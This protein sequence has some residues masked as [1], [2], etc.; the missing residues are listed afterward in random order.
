[1]R[2]NTSIIYNFCLLVGDGLSIV[3]GLS[4]AYILRVS[5]DHRATSA[6]IYAINYLKFL[7]LLVPFWLIVFG[8]LGLYKESGYQNRFIELGKVISGSFIGILFLISYSYMLNV[9]IFPA[10]LVVIYG[11]AFSII[12]VLI[13]RNISRETQKHLF[14]VGI[15]TNKAL[16]IG[17]NPSARSLI[18]HLRNKTSGYEVVGIVSA[19]QSN[20]LKDSPFKIY[21][22]F[23]QL[24]TKI[25]GKKVH[26]I[27]QTELYS[28]P[29]KNDQVL[30]FSQNNHIAYKFI[31]G[32]EELFTGNIKTDLFNS[33]PIISVHQTALIGWGKVVKR[34]MD[35]ILGIF[36]VVISSPVWLVVIVLQFISS[37]KNSIFYSTP[38][39]SA[40][41]KKVKIYKFRTIKP[42]YNG[43][44]PEEAFKIM[45]KEY[46]IKE[47][48][49]NGDFLK[50]DP[51]TTKFS[52]F[53]RRYSIDELPQL[54]N[55]I[56]GDISLVGP[57]ALD[58]FELN[59]YD[60]KDLIL[61]IKSGLTGLAQISGRRE[62]NFEE[63]RNLD[64]YYV[65]NWSFWFDL[66]ILARTFSVVLFHKGAI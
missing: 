3:F 25:N 7:F 12:S 10:R 40:Y 33:I 54:L 20:Y 1:M 11:F 47:Y 17:D 45:G 28:S 15:G 14:K 43:L 13:F 48:R 30:A 49:E 27:F 34:L 24:I 21:T 4:V 46:L 37:P 51:R 23:D 35:L 53:I 18:D 61:S 19:H 22:D 6:H 58:E 41:G 60:K 5:I 42:K 8:I 2:N 65:Q 36:L 31:P 59:K 55:V 57:R 62:I 38:R 44:T 56:K 64:L 63:R 66:I 16:I 29:Q 9:V 26:T 50:D 32:N 39:L 52:R